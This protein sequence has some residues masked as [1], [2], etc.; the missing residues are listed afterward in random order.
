MGGVTARH[1]TLSVRP[2]ERNVARVLSN[3]RRLFVQSVENAF[4][5]V[6]DAGMRSVCRSV[7]KQLTGILME[8][9]IV[10]S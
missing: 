2:P 3:V 4:A 1:G 8:F 7:E 5:A 9:G 6:P 10:A